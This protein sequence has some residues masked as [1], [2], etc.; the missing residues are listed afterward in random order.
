MARHV[1]MKKWRWTDEIT[2]LGAEQGVGVGVRRLGGFMVVVVV[3]PRTF[4]SLKK[5]TVNFS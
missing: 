1:A 5:K 4:L 3:S 2:C